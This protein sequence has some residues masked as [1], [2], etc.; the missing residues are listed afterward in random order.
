MRF[1]K[2]AI[3]QNT[4]EG[5]FHNKNQSLFLFILINSFLFQCYIIIPVKYYVSRPDVFFQVGVFKN[6]AKIHRKTTQVAQVLV[7]VFSYEF[8]DIFK[9]TFF[10]EHIGATASENT[11]KVWNKIE[12]CLQNGSTTIYSS[13][14]IQTGLEHKVVVISSSK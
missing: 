14:F 5:P 1:F 7:E 12:N 3:L 8:C 2:V 4:C 13:A 6:F 9:N 11:E 10:I